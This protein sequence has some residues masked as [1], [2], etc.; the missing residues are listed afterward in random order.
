MSRFLQH[1]MNELVVRD[2]KLGR[3]VEEI[4]DVIRHA[5]HHGARGVRED[6][7]GAVDLLPRGHV[8]VST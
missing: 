2:P 6:G 1:P 7:A 4:G 5:H 3:A 8:Q